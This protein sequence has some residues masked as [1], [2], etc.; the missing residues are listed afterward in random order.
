M[1]PVILLGVVIFAL[2]AILTQ[3][4]TV[5]LVDQDEE[6]GSVGLGL[7]AL[8]ATDVF[9]VASIDDIIEP[10]I[11]YDFDFG[12]RKI[13]VKI[14]D[15]LVWDVRRWE[16]EQ[17]NSIAAAGGSDVTRELFAGVAKDNTLDKTGF[18]T[19][20]PRVGGEGNS[21]AGLASGTL[22]VMNQDTLPIIDAVLPFGTTFQNETIDGTGQLN[23]HYA[24]Y[25][26]KSYTPYGGG[27]DGPHRH[28][29]L[30]HANYYMYA[31]TTAY[32]STVAS[33][34][35]AMDAR[36]MSIDIEELFADRQVILNLA[37]ALTILTV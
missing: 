9:S 15:I 3:L 18:P 30:L 10:T 36:L 13:S 32:T 33:L 26:E 27:G 7:F 21:V 22:N 23:H 12:Q 2:F 20:Q 35:L 37:D 34:S 24:K 16:A 14:E 25:A 5:R 19:V 28:H 4:K 31:N 29:M 1:I 8:S 11:I 6:Y 17:L